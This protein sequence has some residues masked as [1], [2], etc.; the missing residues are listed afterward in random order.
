MGELLPFLGLQKVYRPATTSSITWGG[1]P[2]RSASSG[3]AEE[4]GKEALSLPNRGRPASI[5]ACARVRGK[6]VDKAADKVSFPGGRHRPRARLEGDWA[7]GLLLFRLEDPDGNSPRSELHPRQGP[8]FRPTRPIS[9]SNDPNWGPEPLSEGLHRRRPTAGSSS[10]KFALYDLVR[11]KAP[12]LCSRA[13]RGRSA[14]H[15]ISARPMTRER[16]VAERKWGKAALDHQAATAGDPEARTG[17]ACRGRPGAGLSAIA[18]CH[19]GMT[20]A[21]APVR[22]R[23]PMSMAALTAPL[24]RL[25]PLHQPHNLRRDRLHRPNGR[26]HLPQ[27]AC[28]ITAFHRTQPASRRKSSPCRARSRPSGVA[29]AMAFHGLSYDFNRV[30]PRRDGAGTC[31]GRA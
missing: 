29:P 15:R 20:Y 26:R 3:C 4:H 27:V 10:I 11:A 21:A 7:P 5:S 13:D 14:W 18:W 19:G 2:P 16:F 23:W 1:P 6:T 30:A 28:S 25:A 31:F 24:C 12:A 22:V 8:A 9:P 17:A